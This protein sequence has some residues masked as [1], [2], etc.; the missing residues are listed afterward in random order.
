LRRGATPHVLLQITD[1]AN[2]P[3]ASCD[4]ASAVGLRVYPPNDRRSV[5]VP[6]AFRGCRK[7]GPV[8]LHLRTTVSGAGIPGFSG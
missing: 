4:P 5:R 1:V 6:Y 7:S 3:S 8:Y 2:F